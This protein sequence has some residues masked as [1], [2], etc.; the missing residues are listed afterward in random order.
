MLFLLISF[1]SG[2]MTVSYFKIHSPA[3]SIFGHCSKCPSAPAP[4]HYILLR[5]LGFWFGC[6]KLNLIS[7]I[8][9]HFPD[10]RFW[11]LFLYSKVFTVSK[12]LAKVRMEVGPICNSA[13]PY[14][15]YLS[16]VKLAWVALLVLEQTTL[17]EVD[18]TFGGRLIEKYWLCT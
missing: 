3:L 9:E 16:S 10:L 6:C 14:L 17:W 1:V 4:P 15:K 13:G 5:S 8:S 7:V 2:I 18:V 12:L 11:I